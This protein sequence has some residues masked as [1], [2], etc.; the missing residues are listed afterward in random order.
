MRFANVNVPKQPLRTPAS[1]LMR[2]LVGEPLK[3]DLPPMKAQDLPVELDQRV[4]LV[5]E[6]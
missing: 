3:R 1:E 6:W 5:G 2:R 4:R